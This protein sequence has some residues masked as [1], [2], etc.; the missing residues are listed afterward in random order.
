MVSTARELLQPSADSALYDLYCGYGLF[1][2]CMSKEVKSVTGVELSPYAVD[3]AASNA[4]RM[5]AENARFHRQDISAESIFKTLQRCGRKD[6]VI[7]DPPRKGAA[8]GVIESIASQKPARVLHV[9]CNI[10]LIPDDL[11]G[12]KKNGYAVSEAVPLDN[13]PGTDDVEMMVL[14]KR[15][16]ASVGSQPE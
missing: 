13:F 16:D 2:L 7:L 9:F 12:W 10:D 3:S 8:E 6:I 5:H 15:D 14:L 11:A 4:K 1:S